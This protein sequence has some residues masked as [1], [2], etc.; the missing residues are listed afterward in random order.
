MKNLQ[1]NSFRHA[2]VKHPCFTLIELLVVIAIIAI[3]AAILLPALNSARERGRSASCINNMKQLN[4]GIFFYCDDH[5]DNFMPPIDTL[6][7]HDYSD[8]RF[9]W[10]ATSDDPLE[11]YFM[12][13]YL[14]INSLGT[15]A[16][17]NVIDCPTNSEGY[18]PDT[19]VDYAYN[20][21]LFNQPGANRP[22]KVGR[23]DQPSKRVTFV[24]ALRHSAGL[25]NP[26]I[27]VGATSANNFNGAPYKAANGVQYIHNNT[28]NVGWV[29]G[30]VSAERKV[31][32][33]NVH[34]TNNNYF[35]QQ[36]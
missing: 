36:I 6:E 25:V 8:Y 35:D 1:S 17:S 21:Y 14:K 28:A 29:D 26:Y 15:S 16:N 9:W 2:G 33:S 20:L 27:G 18:S 34:P 5:D 13:P 4:T 12:T 7:G 24:D 10:N 22:G 32:Y 11:N 23:V 3:L 19:I 30:H 31:Y